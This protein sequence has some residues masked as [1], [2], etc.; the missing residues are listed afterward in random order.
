MDAAVFIKGE[1][2]LINTSRATLV[3]FDYIANKNHSIPEDKRKLI[4]EF[5]RLTPT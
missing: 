1:D 5:E 2:E 4:I 3:W